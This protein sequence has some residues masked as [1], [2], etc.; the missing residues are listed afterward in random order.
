ML[1]CVYTRETC[2]LSCGNLYQLLG[3]GLTEAAASWMHVSEGYEVLCTYCRNGEKIGSVI[4]GK[5]KCI[6]IIA[7]EDV[8][9]LG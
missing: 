6:A 9:D 2:K 8:N 3:I 7:V 1:L 5:T 4:C